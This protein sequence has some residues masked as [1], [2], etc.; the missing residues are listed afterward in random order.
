GSEERD[1]GGAP[2]QEPMDRRESVLSLSQRLWSE[3]E[4]RGQDDRLP[5]FGSLHNRYLP[6][7][8]PGAGKIRQPE[9]PELSRR[10]TAIRRCPVAQNR[11]RGARNQSDDLLELPWPGASDI[12]PANAR[13]CR[14]PPS[15]GEDEMRL[16]RWEAWC[17]TLGF[18]L[19]LVFILVPG[20]YPMAIFTFV[21]Q[22]L[23][24]IAVVGY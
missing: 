7:T 12:D 9:L 8:D 19:T 15:H 11:A 2:L 6:R 17:A 4:P 13:L 14:L 20:P 10:H 5:A 24:A 21:A 16:L 23:F 18:V 1:A 22:P 3:R